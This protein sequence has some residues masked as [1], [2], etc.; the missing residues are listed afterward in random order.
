MQ[1]KPDDAD[2]AAPGTRPTTKP[3]TKV[4]GYTDL[5]KLLDN[6][7]IDAISTATPNH[8]HALISIWGVQAGKDV[9]VEKPVSHNVWEGRKIVDAPA[10]TTRSCRPA[11]RA[12]RTWP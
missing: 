9:Y 12:A 3:A 11:P 5:R 4:E 8:W 10:S 2:A 7:D 1:G 6:K